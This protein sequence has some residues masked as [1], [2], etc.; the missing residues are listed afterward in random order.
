MDSFKL[1]DAPKPP[2]RGRTPALVWNVLTILILVA[3]LC[4][5]SIFLLIYVDP[6][7]NLNPFPPPT[8]F[9][10]VAPPTATVTPRFT[11]VPTWTQTISTSQSTATLQ[12]TNLPEVA[13]TD[14]LI[15]TATEAA[16][17]APPGG[18]AF[19]LQQGSPSAIDAAAFHPNTTCNWMGVAGQA[20]SLNDEGVRGLFVKLGGSLPGEEAVEN[21]AMT[22][23]APQYGP[24]GYEI[25]VTDQ[26]LATTGS[27]WIQLLDQQNLPIS[28][29]VY[30]DTY[31]DCKKNLI[32]IYFDQ[33]R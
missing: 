21:L 31:D 29:R 14:F 15:P 9:P 1:S 25:T 28:D 30:F 20:T 11:L 19:E 18:F 26:L 7:N 2:R 17:I 33:V 27:M 3:M 13:N 16:P 32:I 8:L 22:G 5:A 23:L 12:P 4:V 24:G 6:N 10:S